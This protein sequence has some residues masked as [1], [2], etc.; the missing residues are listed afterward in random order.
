MV[1]VHSC[2]EVARYRQPAVVTKQKGV[3]SAKRMYD[4]YS[5]AIS[6]MLSHCP[7]RYAAGSVRRRARNNARSHWSTKTWHAWVQSTRN[8]WHT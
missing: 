8:T 7:Y 1:S 2:T 3:L 6:A 4:F 5:K